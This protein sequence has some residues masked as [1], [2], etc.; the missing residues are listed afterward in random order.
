MNIKN[1]PA[2]PEA[3]NRETDIARQQESGFVKLQNGIKEPD[4]VWNLNISS[5]VKTTEESYSSV[6]TIY[7]QILDVT[8]KQVIL[9]CLLDKEQKIFQTRKFDKIPFENTVDLT[10]DKFVEIKIYTRPGE[11]K[12]TY[13]NIVADAELKEIFE[14]E[15]LTHLFDSS[16]FTPITE[17]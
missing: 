1:R 13:K 8:P 7:A 5:N 6:E 11:R 9:N 2:P 17:S 4:L 14:P 15:D 10:L 3:A 16:F 12:F